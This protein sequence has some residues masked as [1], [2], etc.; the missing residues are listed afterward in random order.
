MVVEDPQQDAAIALGSNNQGSTI[1]M[2]Y[3]EDV[4]ILACDK[5][6]VEQYVYYHIL[7]CNH[8]SFYLEAHIDYKGVP[9][10]C[11]VV[12][13]NCIEHDHRL[14]YYCEEDLEWPVGGF[15]FLFFYQSK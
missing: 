11:M 15:Y 2:A 3:V 4:R 7:P 13:N 1:L 5:W 6:D 9:H 8:H 10:Q 14:N 12:V